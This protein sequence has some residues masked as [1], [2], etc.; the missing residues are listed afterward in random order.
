VRFQYT[1]CAAFAAA[2][3]KTLARAH[4]AQWQG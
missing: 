4:K 2:T 3:L 1:G